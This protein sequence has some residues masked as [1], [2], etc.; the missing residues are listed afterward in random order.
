MV[1]WCFEVYNYV[2][3]CHTTLKALILCL[4]WIL[5]C[6]YLILCLIF[7]V[8]FSCVAMDTFFNMSV[9]FQFVTLLRKQVAL[10]L[11]LGLHVVIEV[12]IQKFYKSLI[13][14]SSLRYRWCK[15]LSPRVWEKGGFTGIEALALGYEFHKYLIVQIYNDLYFMSMIK[16]WS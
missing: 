8:M 2:P 3:S 4:V 10:C 13:D 11:I 5:H 7:F 6:E 15:N 16:M 1:P 12:R 14:W 9:L